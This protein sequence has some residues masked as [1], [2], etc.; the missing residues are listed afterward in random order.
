MEQKRHWERAEERK[1][2]EKKN[3]KNKAMG[4]DRWERRGHEEDGREGRG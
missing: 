4:E 3:G 2:K 1:S